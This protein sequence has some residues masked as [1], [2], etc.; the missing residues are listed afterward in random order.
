MYRATSVHPVLERRVLLAAIG[1]G[2][3]T[4]FEIV[5][6]ALGSGRPVRHG[7]LARQ[8]PHDRQ[9]AP[10]DAPAGITRAAAVA[11]S[12]GRKVA[13]GPLA[14]VEAGLLQRCCPC[15]RSGA[16]TISI[17]SEALNTIQPSRMV[18]SPSVG[19]M[20]RLLCACTKKISDPHRNHDLGHHQGQ[21]HEHVEG[22]PPA[23]LHPRQRERRGRAQHGR[24]QRR[25]KRD[26][27]AGLHG[28]HVGGIVERGVEPAG[29]AAVPDGH[30]T[31]PRGVDTAGVPQTE[32]SVATGTNIIVRT[33]GGVIGTQV[34]VSIVASHVTATGLPAERGYLISFVISA[35]ALCAAT[36]VALRAPAGAAHRRLS[37]ERR[38]PVP[39]D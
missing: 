33:I 34:A 16:R 12:P 29:G 3:A 20:L 39:A 9:G 35:V 8:A 4:L 26:P 27:E 1:D 6:F 7:E 24:D 37:L 18:D 25:A 14:E 38:R 28:G 30:V 21:V 22:H 10:S 31:H 5:Q 19:K 11:A 15:P 17:T 23:L 2:Q 36:F 32:T 13:I